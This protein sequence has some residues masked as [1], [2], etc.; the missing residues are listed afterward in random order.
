M[1]ERSKEDLEYLIKEGRVIDIFL[2]VIFGAVLVNMIFH[3]IFLKYAIATHSFIALLFILWIN[4]ALIKT[5]RGFRSQLSDIKKRTREQ[6]RNDQV[7]KPKQQPKNFHDFSEN[8][9]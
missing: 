1:I 6:L 2:S 3:F 9:Y 5:T 4:R 7:H 8:P